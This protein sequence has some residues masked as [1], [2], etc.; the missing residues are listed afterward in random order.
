MATF[1]KYAVP[2]EDT[3]YYA[4]APPIQLQ[5]PRRVEWD[6]DTYLNLRLLAVPG[7][8]DSPTYYMPVRY[9]NNGTSEECWLMFKKALSKVLIGQNITT[10]PH[11][12][13]MARRLI[14]GAALR[15]FDDSALLPVHGAETLVHYE[16]VM[17]DMTNYVFPT[18][19]LQIQKRY[20]R[21]H[22]RKKL[23]I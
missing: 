22:M 1:S 14:E 17:R 13:G 19:A 12:Y 23:L 9:F 7:N 3:Q 16:E 11:T 2:P 18:R 4:A 6:S 10:G 8:N 15:K 5:R 20:M 21:R